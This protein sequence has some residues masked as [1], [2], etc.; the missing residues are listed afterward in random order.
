MIDNP[1]SQPSLETLYKALELAK[2]DNNEKAA[3]DIEKMIAARWPERIGR[4]PG[5]IARGAAVPLTGAAAGGAVG[6]PWG[7]LVGGAALP[8]ADVAMYGAKKMGLADQYRY[9]S[10]VVSGLLTQAGLPQPLSREERML[11]AAGAGAGGVGGAIRGVAMRTAPKLAEAIGRSAA[12]KEAQAAAKKLAEAT[13]KREISQIGAGGA[14]GATG[15]YAAE[16]V[17]EETESPLAAMGAG[18]LAG[19]LTAG[20]LGGFRLP[21]TASAA[22][23]YAEAAK[24]YAAIPG[25]LAYDAGALAQDLNALTKKLDFTPGIHPKAAAVL[26]RYQEIATNASGV[27]PIQEILSLRQIA[28]Q[29]WATADSNDRR[30]INQ[31]RDNIDRFVDDALAKGKVSG[32]GFVT[33]AVARGTPEEAKTAARMLEE[34]NTAYRQ[35]STSTM[36]LE[37]IDESKFAKGDFT[38]TLKNK[39][40]AIRENKDQWNRLSE[41]EQNQIEK[42]LL[43][44]KGAVNKLVSGLTDMLGGAAGAISGASLGYAAGQLFPAEL[45]AVGPS[46]GAAVGA[47]APKAISG[48][49]QAGRSLVPGA[50]PAVV[51]EMARRYGGTRQPY[52]Y[53]T[54]ALGAQP[55]GLLFPEEER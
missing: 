26:D 6:G 51:E 18:L 38:E 3:K 45:A 23:R 19:G 28:N 31:I 22:P 33:S 40:R 47:L 9:P 32:P 20:T 16:K 46:M 13:T 48:A 41:A 43:A 14:A 42:L 29:A 10:D 17:Y 39:L 8:L 55:G 44:D 54:P 34:A 53:P 36:L 35:A 7:A 30:I 2:G 12:S 24:K 50:S 5:L 52:S 25:G 37:A 4:I 21:K 49:M 27:V 15:E 1:Q 11:E